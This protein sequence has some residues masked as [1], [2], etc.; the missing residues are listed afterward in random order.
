MDNGHILLVEDDPQIRLMTAQYFRREGFRVSVAGDV[1]AAR[2]QIEAAAPDI[3]L[4]DVM[5]PGG[6]GLDLCRDLRAH[7][8]LPII[9][10]T[11]RGEEADRVAGLEVGADDYVTKPFSLRELLA[12]VRAVLRRAGARDKVEAG[13]DQAVFDGWRF[14][15]RKRELLSPAGVYVDISTAEYDM[16]CVFVES[17]YVPLTRAALIEVLKGR[18]FDASDRIIDVQ[19]SRLR[20]KF[21]DV[22]QAIFRSVR[23]VGYVFSPKQLSRA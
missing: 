13:G 8:Q 14:D 1:R 11:A 12:R 18:A 17:P 7:T 10:L 19:V 6:N 5:L 20:R 9:L 21:D 23:G 3:M 22:D 4:L 16:L 2:Q 15:I